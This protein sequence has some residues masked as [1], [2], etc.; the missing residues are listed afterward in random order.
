MDTDFPDLEM[1]AQERMDSFLRI[2]VRKI[3]Q[4]ADCDK[5][6]DWIAEH[7]EYLLPE[8]VAHLN[9]QIKSAAQIFRALGREIWQGTPLPHKKYVHE[10]LPKPGRND[11]CYCGSDRKF[12]HCCGQ[13]DAAE[14]G[15]ERMELLPYVLDVLPKK[16][17][18]E[19]PG[20]GVPVDAIA[21]AAFQFLD[22][23]RPEDVV[24]LLTPWFGSEGR[25]PD[26]QADMFDM[27]LD[28][29]EWLGKRKKRKDL[30]T[31]ATVRGEPQVAAVG[32]QRLAAM[33]ADDGDLQGAWAAFTHAQRADP[34]NVA[35]GMLELTILLS[36]KKWEQAAQRARFWSTRTA[37]LHGAQYAKLQEYFNSVAQDPR[38]AVQEM[39]RN[40]V[41]GLGQLSALL[42]SAPA[43]ACAYRLQPYD[44]SAGPLEPTPPLQKARA[45]W[46]KAFPSA[47]PFSVQ[48]SSYNAQ[49]WTA[50]EPWLSV[51]SAHP[52]LWQDFDVLD[53]LVC[54]VDGL[55]T[56][57]LEDDVI[58]RLTSRALVLLDCVLAD[59]HAAGLKLEWG[60]ME[61]RPALRL[62]VRHIFDSREAGDEATAA[63]WTERMVNQLNPNDNHGLRDWM[64]RYYLQTG[65]IEQAVALGDRYP[66]DFAAM[67]Y[68]RALAHYR[69]G[70]QEQADAILLDALHES[71]LVGKALLAK[72]A[73]KPKESG[74]ITIGSQ[75][76]ANHYRA[77]H[78]ALWTGDAL[79]WLAAHRNS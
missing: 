18:A 52:I 10:H 8:M 41:P 24:K 53:D 30:A 32:W 72:R 38:N 39:N 48:M 79:T 34:D 19:L 64:M 21:A 47:V 16:R 46:N 31:A 55:D 60:F 43:V 25:W 15:L 17:W 74:T 69:A 36:Q 23:E 11:P 37:K 78:L 50:P 51:L 65:Q 45:K 26:R 1:S 66:D 56:L 5:F 27:L 4:L 59:Q 22:E 33:L 61:N 62:I 13:W 54:A 68:N 67:R 76:E 7:G 71:P 29:Y 20:S 57:A 73:G 12:K 42:A 49:A 14:L 70:H 3:V 63:A 58:R 28:A 75:D 40:I 44:G 6:L 9:P 35:L 2:C 77:E